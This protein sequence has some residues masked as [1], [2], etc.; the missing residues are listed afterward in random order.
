ML[1]C[2]PAKNLILA[3]GGAVVKAFR[4]LAGVVVL[5][6]VAA[7]P[8][9]AQAVAGSQLSGVVRDSSNAAIPGAEVTVT[10]TDTGSSDFT[11]FGFT[12]KD[13]K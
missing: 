3:T 4:S 6:L 7:A 10:K 13:E 9:W 1:T 11:N 12:K 2:H 5:C 8:A